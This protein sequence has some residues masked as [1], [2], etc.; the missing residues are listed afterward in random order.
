MDQFVLMA[1]LVLEG[2]W[3][4]SP[5]ETLLLLHLY[6]GTPRKDYTTWLVSCPTFVTEPKPS[7]RPLKFT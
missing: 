3:G 2:Y 6:Q 7:A 4:R 1:L 5:G